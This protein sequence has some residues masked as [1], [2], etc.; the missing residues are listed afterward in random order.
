[1][2][3]L[4]SFAFHAA[5]V[6]TIAFLFIEWRVP[7]FV[8]YVFPFYWLVIVTTVLGFFSVRSADKRGLEQGGSTQRSTPTAAVAVLVGLTLMSVILD[9]GDVFSFM[10]IPMAVVGLVAPIILVR[11]SS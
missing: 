7:G 5:L 8:S 6:T 10:R 9:S 2:K 4:I 3:N 11:Y 1:M